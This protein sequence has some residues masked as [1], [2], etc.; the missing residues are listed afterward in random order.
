[1]SAGELGTEMPSSLRTAGEADLGVVDCAADAELVDWWQDRKD[2]WDSDVVLD[3]WDSV[4][5]SDGYA[6]VHKTVFFLEGVDD[7]PLDPE[8]QLLVD[9]DYRRFAALCAEDPK[10]GIFLAGA[11]LLVGDVTLRDHGV[12]PGMLLEMRARPTGGAGDSHRLAPLAVLRVQKCENRREYLVGSP[13]TTG[14]L[15]RATEKMIGRF[16]CNLPSLLTDVSDKCPGL[17]PEHMWTLLGCFETYA[18][19]LL[20]FSVMRYVQV[21]HEEYHDLD[22]LDALQETR[23]EYDEVEH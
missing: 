7:R 14:A 21:R 15:T 19:A 18:G 4:Q 9:A 3:Q 11:A 1:M 22:D 2:G 13:A 23:R 8:G 6:E 20:D 5:T 10:H 17:A 12:A 16:A